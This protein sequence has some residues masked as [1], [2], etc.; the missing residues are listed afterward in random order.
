[1]GN[2][3]GPIA[4]ALQSS[5]VLELIGNSIC[6]VVISHWNIFFPCKLSTSMSEEL[7]LFK[8]VY[9]DPIQTLGHYS[10]QYKCIHFYA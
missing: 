9:L 8:M 10:S 1:M 3:T 2:G 4:Q 6:K 7:I 5:G